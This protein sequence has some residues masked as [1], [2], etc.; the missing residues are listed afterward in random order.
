[1][2]AID[3]RPTGNDAV[4]TFIATLGTETDTFSPIPTGRAAFRECMF[5]RGAGSTDGT[6]DFAHPMPAVV[7]KSAQHFAAGFAP[8]C[9]PIASVAAPGTASPDFAALRL[10]KAGRPL[11]PQ[12]ADPF[13]PPNP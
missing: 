1:M 13:A 4:K 12:V 10:P 3:D 7:V 2:H 5:H 9:D 6:S 8:A 11:W